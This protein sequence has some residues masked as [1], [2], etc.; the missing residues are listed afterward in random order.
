MQSGELL[1]L[2]QLHIGHQIMNL[3]LVSGQKLV[4]LCRK[5]SDVTGFLF[6]KQCP[7]GNRQ[8]QEKHILEHHCLI[9]DGE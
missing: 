2:S 8:M 5:T 6:P 1:F 4:R 7:Q 3:L 9:Q